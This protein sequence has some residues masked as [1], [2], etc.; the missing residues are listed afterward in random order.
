MKEWD[1]TGKAGPRVPLPDIVTVHAPKEEEYVTG[2]CL[3][4]VGWEH[5]SEVEV[6]HITRTRI[7]VLCCLLH[8]CQRHDL[9]AYPINRS[10]ACTF[11][12]IPP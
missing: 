1:P 9:A 11:V 4:V 6:G 2:A 7:T 10:H 12:Y 3:W 5:V 8:A